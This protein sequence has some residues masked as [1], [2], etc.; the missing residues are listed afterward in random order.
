VKIVDA[1]VLIYAVNQDSPQHNEARDWLDRALSLPAGG[2]EPIGLAWVVLLAFWRVTTHPAIFPSPLPV[3]TAGTIIEA[4][5]G[6][7]ATIIV[8]PTPRHLALLSGLL[9]TSGAGANLVNDAHLA[10]LALEHGA[11]L[12]SYDHDLTRFAGVQVERPAA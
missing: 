9:T 3:A 5:L 11:T 7:P 1:N 4:W 10:A 12:I 2:G 6:R 8:S